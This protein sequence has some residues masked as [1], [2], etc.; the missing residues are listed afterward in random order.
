MLRTPRLLASLAAAA[1]SADSSTEF[2]SGFSHSTCLPAASA[3]IAISKCVSPGV[4]M[5][6][7]SISGS[8]TRSCHR[9][10]VCSKP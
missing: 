5:S 2:A 1:I 7:T 3:A 10:V 4:Q 9:V 8:S 6:M